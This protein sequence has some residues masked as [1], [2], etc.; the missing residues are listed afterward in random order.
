M[1]RISNLVFVWVMRLALPLQG[2][3]AA[4]MIFCQSAHER[5]LQVDGHAHPDAQAG[6]HAH[7]AASQA[8][9]TDGSEPSCSACAVCCLM[10]AIAAERVAP[11]G[12]ELERR[13]A[14]SPDSEIASH[15]PDGLER[16]PRDLA[17]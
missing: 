14:L 4:L 1:R 6:A 8:D 11:G 10:S 3:A 2:A 17:A 15:M 9:T 12:L 13:I 5:T 7:H 16:P